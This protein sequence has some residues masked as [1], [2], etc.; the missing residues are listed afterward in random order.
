MR[1]NAKIQIENRVF[2][3]ETSNSL[4]PNSLFPIPLFFTFSSAFKFFK[5]KSKR[6]QYCKLIPATAFSIYFLFP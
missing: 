1:L 4:F 6:P 2:S 3:A 5:E